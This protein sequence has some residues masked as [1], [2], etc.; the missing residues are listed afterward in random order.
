MKERVFSLFIKYISDTLSVQLKTQVA[1]LSTL[2]FTQL[3]GKIV[4]YPFKCGGNRSDFY[5]SCWDEDGEIIEIRVSLCWV[6]AGGVCSSPWTAPA[7]PDPESASKGPLAVG[8]CALNPPHGILELNNL[9]TVLVIP[10]L[11]HFPVK[12][13]RIL[14]GT[15]SPWWQT[16][17][18]AWAPF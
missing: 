14:P 3:K 9:I 7:Q 11:W 1:P 16:G 8:R 12:R 4:V 6:G 5:N 13:V 2:V 10:N 18:E 17:G 15:A